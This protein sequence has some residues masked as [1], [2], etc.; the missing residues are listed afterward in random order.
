[1][2]RAG[3]LEE[4]MM[5]TWVRARKACV[6][7]QKGMEWIPSARSQVLFV[8]FRETHEDGRGALSLIDP[9]VPKEAYD[10]CQVHMASVPCLG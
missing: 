2:E 8:S 5:G 6:W 9:F 1:M 3:L 7:F 4:V 10:P